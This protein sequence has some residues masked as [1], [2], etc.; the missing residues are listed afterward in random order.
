MGSVEL[1]PPRGFDLEKRIAA[2][3]ALKEAGV[4]TINVADGNTPGKS[5]D[6]RVYQ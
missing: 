5:S 6:E 1:N 4:T 3:K 2:M